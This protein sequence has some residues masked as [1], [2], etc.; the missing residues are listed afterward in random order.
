MSELHPLHSV[1]EVYRGVEI[2]RHEPDGEFCAFINLCYHHE[3]TLEAMKLAIDESDEVKE[4]E[5][6]EK[7]HGL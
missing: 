1:I 3:D 4:L 7:P 5:H 6:K 2:R